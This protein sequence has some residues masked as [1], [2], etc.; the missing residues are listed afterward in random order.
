MKLSQRLSQLNAMVAATYDQ[1]WDCCCDH[2]LLGAALLS[3]QLP[4]QVHFVDIVPQLMQQLECKLQR[5]DPDSH[6]WHTHCI[7]VATLPLTRYP[8]RSLII[9]AGVGGELMAH[10]VAT[11]CSQHPQRPLDFLLCPTNQTYHLRQQLI[12]LE[13]G[14]LQEVLVAENQRFYEV[15]LVS[16]QPQHHRPITAIGEQLWQHD[17]KDECA[18]RQRYQRKLLTHYQQLSKGYGANVTPIINAYRA[19]TLA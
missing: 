9:I 12:T 16:T 1:I 4:A 14:L 11:I 18:L 15:L 8:G 6:Q 5:F 7:D 19:L 17:S 13:L 10:F 2:G 3:R